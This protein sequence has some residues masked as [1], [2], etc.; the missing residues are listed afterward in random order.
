MKVRFC[1]NEDGRLRGPNKPCE[2]CICEVENEQYLAA[3]RVVKGTVGL[4]P[5]MEGRNRREWMNKRNEAI[6]RAGYKP[7][8]G[9]TFGRKG[10]K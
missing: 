7:P 9:V 6:Q 1:V 3:P 2:G 4:E 8:D 5:T 10:A